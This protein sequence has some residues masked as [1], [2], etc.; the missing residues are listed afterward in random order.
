MDRFR[1]LRGVTWEPL[2]GEN[3][4]HS[5]VTT[6][7]LMLAILNFLCAGF[8]W[9]GPI[10][11]IPSR[12]LG[13]LDVVVFILLIAGPYWGFMKRKSLVRGENSTGAII[14]KWERVLAEFND[15]NIDE[16]AN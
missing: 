9:W 15:Q 13:W 2:K 7:S 3:R 5:Y 12:Q 14:A 6:I 4:K 16:D 1:I 11:Q 8:C 10:Q